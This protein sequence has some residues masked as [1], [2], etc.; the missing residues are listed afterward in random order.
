MAKKKNKHVDETSAEEVTEGI[1]KLVQ[2]NIQETIVI[3]QEEDEPQGPD[4]GDVAE[5]NEIPKL[6]VVEGEVVGEKVEDP[7]AI[8]QLSKPP[9]VERVQQERITQQPNA[10]VENLKKTIFDKHANRGQLAVEFAKAILSSQGLKSNTEQIVKRS[11]EITDGIQV[12]IDRGYNA[13]M[14]KRI[15]GQ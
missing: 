10:M 3:D 12:E 15:T 6:E 7:A 1:Q 11:F 4:V 14:T 5:E 13:E 8:A 2:G 9:F